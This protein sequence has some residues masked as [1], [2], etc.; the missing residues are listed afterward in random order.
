[1]LAYPLP[2]GLL[3]WLSNDVLVRRALPW[4]GSKEVR[5]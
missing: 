4:R 2:A 3:A 1:L 5:R